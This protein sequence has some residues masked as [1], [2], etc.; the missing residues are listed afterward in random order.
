MIARGRRRDA[1]D[2][3]M[4]R[5]M[6]LVLDDAWSAPSAA[7]QLRELVPDQTVLRRTRARVSSALADRAS[8]VAERAVATLDLAVGLCEAE[9]PGTT[10]L[11]GGAAMGEQVLRW[12][13]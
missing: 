4:F 9:P 7:A 2:L 3:A 12:R 1:V 8:T 6:R 11:P 10:A 5:L 13:R